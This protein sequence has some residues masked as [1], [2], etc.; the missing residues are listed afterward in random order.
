MTPETR[1]AE[2]EKAVM[3]CGVAMMT[4]ELD[5][6]AAHRRADRERKRADDWE[7][8]RGWLRLCA[9]DPAGHAEFYQWASHYF[10]GT[11]E[12]EEG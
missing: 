10:F 6:R 5:A 4:A 9:D 11:P 8:L 7:D 1:I 2:L 12:P 3:D